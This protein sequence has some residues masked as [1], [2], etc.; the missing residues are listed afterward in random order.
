MP[1]VMLSRVPSLRA[2]AYFNVFNFV[3]Y[4][5]FCL[6]YFQSNYTSL[7]FKVINFNRAV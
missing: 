7:N 4:A 6:F 1:I 5:Y 3:K 2:E